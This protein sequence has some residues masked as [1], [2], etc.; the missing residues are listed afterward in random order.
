MHTSRRAVLA[1]GTGLIAGMTGCT[2]T[3][4]GTPTRMP[5]AKVYLG[6]G[7]VSFEL[8]GVSLTGQIGADGLSGEQLETNDEFNPETGGFSLTGSGSDR[9]TFTPG[10]LGA[11][12]IIADNGEF[13][14]FHEGEL[15]DQGTEQF[16]QTF[17]TGSRKIP[18]DYGDFSGGLTFTAR[19]GFNHENDNP[20]EEYAIVAREVGGNNAGSVERVGEFE[21]G[22]GTVNADYPGGRKDYYQ[23]EGLSA[24]YAGAAVVVEGPDF[25]PVRTKLPHY[26]AFQYARSHS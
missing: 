13:D 26:R 6:E 11:I 23:V 12:T 24:L 3:R 21:I 9:I 15:L 2:Q 8:N 10:S 5:G 22:G 16:S 19:A 25:D 7:V 20:A 18:P 17:E 4:N 1:T 14:I